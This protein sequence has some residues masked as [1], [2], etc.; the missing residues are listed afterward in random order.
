[1]PQNVETHL[2]NLHTSDTAR[3]DAWDEGGRFVEARKVTIGQ[4]LRE[5]ITTQKDTCSANRWSACV[6]SAWL[7]Q[8]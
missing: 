3:A 4:W 8:A 2:R 6:S 5:W 7:P 1:M